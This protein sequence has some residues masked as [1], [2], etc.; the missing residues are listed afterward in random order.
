MASTPYPPYARNTH[1]GSD[2]TLFGPLVFFLIALVILA[3]TLPASG[4]RVPGSRYVYAILD[5]IPQPWKPAK[6]THVLPP[7]VVSEP[8]PALENPPQAAPAAQAQRITVGGTAAQ[9]VPAPA[10][11]QPAAPTASVAEAPVAA[12]HPAVTTPLPATFKLDGFRHQWQTWNNCGPATITMAT[13]YFGRSE[14]QAQAVP[15]LKPNANDKNVNPD[16]LVAYARSLGLSADW[17]IAGDTDRLKRLLANS[18]PVVVETWFTP[19]P[20]DGMG[21][22]RLLVGFDDP[23]KQFIAYD[24]YQTPGLN[25]RLSYDRFEEDWRAFN[26]TYIPVYTAEKT[27]VV[28]AIIAGDRDE[29]HMRQRALAKAQEEAAARPQDAYAW[30]NLG[31]SLTAVG[32]T[33]EAV[34]AFDRARSLKLPWRMLWYQFTPF[35]AYLAA[36]RVGDV[37]ALTAANLEQ[38]NDLEESH[39]Y[40]GRALEAQGQVAQARAAYQTAVRFNPRFA[41]AQHALSLLG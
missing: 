24:S 32:R 36:G 16:E 28:D 5:R 33:A 4:V 39:Y 23:A 9:P 29:S 15:F 18:I 22:Y 13:S 31:S 3:A 37:L 34:P 11:V 2:V 30:F 25:V 12:A 41:P 7:E 40:R 26:R 20:N 10:E 17:L 19:H 35:E 1:R 6:P 27:E 14:T 38:A 21:H 8:A